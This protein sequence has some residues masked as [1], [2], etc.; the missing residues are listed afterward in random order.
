MKYYQIS[1][2]A[3]AKI[4]GIKTGTSQVELMVNNIEKNQNYIDF[5]N[6]FSGYNKEFWNNQEIV[7][8]LNP[9]LIKGKLRKGAKITDLMEYGPYYHFLYNIYSEKYITIIKHF[10]IGDY[11]IFDFEINNVTEKYFLLFIKALTYH[12]VNF[13]SS[14]IITG[15]KILNNLKY[16]EIKS[17]DEYIEFKLKNPLAKFEKIAISKEFYGKDIIAIQG[18]PDYFYSE[19]LIDF[20]LDCGITGLEVS[21]KNSIQLEF[22]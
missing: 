9:P 21:Y 8:N 3:D 14:T 17:R 16:H 10:K 1:R 5:E 22:V 2:T 13:N 12:D 7:L 4:I 19:K 15:K 6:H 18:A 11:K 20:L